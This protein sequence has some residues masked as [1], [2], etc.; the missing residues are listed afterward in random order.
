MH[1]ECV[2]IKAILKNSHNKKVNELEY[3][4]SLIHSFRIG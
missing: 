4:N 2:L 3:S 1:L